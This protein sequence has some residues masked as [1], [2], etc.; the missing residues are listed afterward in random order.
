MMQVLPLDYDPDIIADY[1]GRRPVAVATRVTQLL[2]EFAG[3]AC[4]CRWYASRRNV[5]HMLHTRSGQHD[6]ASDGI[7]GLMLPVPTGIAGGFLGGLALDVIQ[8][9][10]EVNQVCTQLQFGSRKP[11]RLCVSNSTLACKASAQPSGLQSNLHGPHRA[12]AE[13]HESAGRVHFTRDLMSC[14]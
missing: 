12:P 7:T 8:D 2:G 6:P 11:E 3:C 1:W 4:C 5:Q 10:L 13:V 14:R 9:K